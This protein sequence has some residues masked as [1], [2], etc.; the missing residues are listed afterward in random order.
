MG[1]ADGRPT[2]RFLVH[3]AE[4]SGPPI[5]VLRLLRAWQLVDPGFRTE[6]VL[7]R[8]GPLAAEI[9]ALAPT[10]TAR[11]DR[12]SPDQLAA[13]GLRAV[14]ARRAAEESTRWSTRLRIGR[15][16]P[17]LTVVNGATAPT[18][19]LLRAAPGGPT[20]MVAHEL[21]TGWEANISAADRLLLLRRCQ[22]FLA[23]SRAVRDHLIDALGVPEHRITVVPPPVDVDDTGPVTPRPRS[24]GAIVVGGGGVTDWRKAPHLWLP[25]AAEV[26]R[27]APGLPMRFVWF[28]GDPADRGRGWPLLHDVRHLGLEDRVEFLGAVDDPDRVLGGLDLFVSTAREDAAPLVCAEAAGAG[29]PV[30]TFDTGGAAELVGDGRCGSTIPYPRVDELARAVVDLARS[31][32]RRRQLGSRGA[33]FVRDHRASPVIGRQVG[34]WVMGAMR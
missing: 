6:V 16:M 19:A 17:A 20:A 25:V 10:R 3:G 9:A 32:D 21:S 2:V 8:P 24:D 13:Q 33:A 28:G 27:L 34:E 29:V 1:P 11:L 22:R 15:T 4:R 7:A 31:P 26:G 14:G 12:R 23:V 18:A 30:L 5:Y